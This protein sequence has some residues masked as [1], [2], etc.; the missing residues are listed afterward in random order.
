MF[1][2][3]SVDSRL[4]GW[5]HWEEQ[6]GFGLVEAM[7]SGLPIVSTD[8]GAIPEVVGSQNLIVPQGS[9]MSMIP[10]LDKI[11]DDRGL[12]FSLGNENRSRA[13]HL[14][15]VE[16]QSECLENEMVRLSQQ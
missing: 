12:R 16:K 14:F 5:T 10:A 4:F 3:P 13:E 11:G 9:V 15:D 1:C 6:F 2:C 7:G 8:C